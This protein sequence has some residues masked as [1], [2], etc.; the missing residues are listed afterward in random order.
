MM[1]L[2]AGS[3]LGPYQILSRIGAGG[4]GEVWK[5]R[6]TRF[7]REVAIKVSAERFTDRFEREA[8]AIAA[9]NHPG[10]CTLFDVGPDYLVMEL[11][12]GPTLAQRIGEGPIGLEEALAI[13]RQIAD[14]LDAA[15]EKGIVHRD[16]KPGNIKIRPDGSVKV[17]D[18]GLAKAGG[19]AAAMTDDSP[20]EMQT[21]AGVI[22]G[23]AAYMAPEQARG[24]PVDK[25]AD[26]WAFGCLLYEMVTS[27][28]PF[29]GDNATDTIASVVKD[30]PDFSR[31]PPPV[32]RLIRRC[33]EKD[34]KRRLRDVGDAWDLLE[35]SSTHSA[36]RPAAPVPRL[37]W[38]GAVAFA[39][40]AGAAAV[41]LLRSETTAGP[42]ISRF[43]HALGGR[44]LPSLATAAG[45]RTSP[46][47]RF[48]FASSTISSLDPF[49][50]PPSV[51]APLRRSFHPMATRSRSSPKAG[52]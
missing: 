13:A 4:M 20:T 42:A 21:Q 40:A 36:A 18:F 43:A 52:S 51:R 49:R 41:W 7:D 2:A 38:I 9:L 31:V 22:L 45:L 12:D 17:L 44:V 39:V 24:K 30:Q 29:R 32:E 25:R 3:R 50:A 47:A 10:I 26:I 1:S 46:T 33:L 14:A 28:R 6:D 23:T 19:G 15:H 11:V 27:A 5:A 37:L 34:P 35:E 8:H 48:I 16:L